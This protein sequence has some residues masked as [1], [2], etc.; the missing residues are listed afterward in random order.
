MSP[1]FNLQHSGEDPDEY[2]AKP[3]VAFAHGLDA[4]SRLAE[5][6]AAYRTVMMA[7]E[8][9]MM[10]DIDIHSC[11]IS[12]PPC[13]VRARWRT[14]SAHYFSGATTIASNPNLRGSARQA[15]NYVIWTYAWP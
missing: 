15:A 13:D 7:N 3:C 4:K 9:R 11:T 14:R 10:D 1:I 12:A 8:Q 6:L 5:V 2:T